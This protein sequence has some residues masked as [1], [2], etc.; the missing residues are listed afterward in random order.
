MSPCTIAVQHFFD[1]VQMFWYIVDTGSRI[2]S[3]SLPPSAFDLRPKPLACVQYAAY[4]PSETLLML[5]YVKYKC[6]CC[7]AFLIK[8]RGEM[9]Y[10]FVSF[11]EE[12]SPALS[13]T[14]WTKTKSEVSKTASHLHH[15]EKTTPT[16]K[17]MLTRRKAPGENSP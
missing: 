1:D 14:P 5:Q 6:V 3:S 12:T 13:A 17:K 8:C 11:P 2:F 16:P 9:V 7:M 4:G 15:G 10:T